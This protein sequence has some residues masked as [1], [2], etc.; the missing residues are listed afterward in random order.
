MG[1]D[2]A[3][4]PTVNHSP[5][6][7]GDENAHQPTV[8]RDDSENMATPSTTKNHSP[9]SNTERSGS[10]SNNEEK[11]RGNPEINVKEE[12]NSPRDSDAGTI[13]RD[14][15]ENINVE[16]IS[17]SAVRNDNNAADSQT[18]VRS[19]DDM[20]GSQTIVRS[21]ENITPDSPTVVRNDTPPRPRSEP[22]VLSDRSTRSSSQRRRSSAQRVAST[23]H[24]PTVVTDEVDGKLSDAVSRRSSKSAV[25]ERRDSV[26]GSAGESVAGRRKI[27]ATVSSPLASSAPGTLRT[28]RKE[29]SESIK[30]QQNAPGGQ[31]DVAD[32]GHR[33]SGD[34]SRSSIS[35]RLHP[36]NSIERDLKSSIGL[37]D[38]ESPFDGESGRI[39]K[40]W[41]SMDN[42]DSVVASSSNI[43]RSKQ[44]H[45]SHLIN[46]LKSVTASENSDSDEQLS[47]TSSPLLHAK[48]NASIKA[49]TQPVDGKDSRASSH[50]PYNVIFES[51]EAASLES[52]LR[53]KSRAAGRGFREKL[54]QSAPSN[55][56]RF[57]G[58]MPSRIVSIR[59]SSDLDANRLQSILDIWYSELRQALLA[60]NSANRERVILE[61]NNSM[62]ELMKS[63]Q[64][65]VDRLHN[66]IDSL[67]R[68]CRSYSKGIHQRDKTIANLAD[69]LAS[70]KE[71]VVLARSFTA[72]RNEREENRRE[73]S[74]KVIASRH[75]RQRIVQRA[76]SAWR[77]LVQERWRQRIEKACQKRAEEVCEQLA[78]RYDSRIAEGIPNLRPEK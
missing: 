36:G 1:D 14:E 63:Q 28:N 62:N 35:Q 25:D 47:R 77:G 75:Y 46:Q 2:S 10:S 31:R 37:L 11:H 68:L 13:V 53:A 41:S 6:G 51:D 39:L 60:E 17:A 38:S 78:D 64:Q 66:D 23:G 34:K 45:V 48:D 29:S 26:P 57:L 74:L 72:W 30:S 54:V 43:P 73:Q 18:M 55:G 49:K 71:Q 21:D 32:T 22:E 59:S 4:S 40:E 19:A 44:Q 8:V 15:V 70:Q 65:D 50:H 58:D 67:H 16:N 33:S 5:K 12:R 3:H 56:P 52:E 7:S 9:K 69:A 24:N 76:W 20:P 27:S 61:F 42:I